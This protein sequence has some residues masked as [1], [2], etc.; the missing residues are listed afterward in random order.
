[1]NR[2]SSLLLLLSSSSSSFCRA[3]S[4]PS[5]RATTT[6][7]RPPTEYYYNTVTRGIHI[8][9]FWCAWCCCW[10]FCVL[11]DLRYYE[12][13]EST[14]TMPV[15]Y[16]YAVAFVDEATGRRFWQ[17]AETG[18]TTWYAFLCVCIFVRARTRFTNASEEEY[19]YG[20]HLRR[21]ARAYSLSL[22][23]SLSH[24]H[25]HTQKPLTKI[26]SFFPFFLS[27][28]DRVYTSAQAISR[29]LGRNPREKQ[30]GSSSL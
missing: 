8:F 15:H 5:S 23:L 20:R 13:T 2:F 16:G 26:F 1:M 6:T 24:S 18:E 7:T 10:L 29:R 9:K 11:C 28:R 14:W 19:A 21:R 12:Q 22:S 30:T 27:S 25:T 3:S 17:H 4:S